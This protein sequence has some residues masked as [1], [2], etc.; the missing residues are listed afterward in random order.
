MGGFNTFE[1]HAKNPYGGD[2]SW[3][4]H[5]DKSI[6]VVEAILP[7]GDRHQEFLIQLDHLAAFFN[8]LVDDDGK[9]I[10]I[11]FRPWHEHTGSWFWWGKENCSEA[12]YI[13]LW[14]FTVNYLSV[15]K[16][17]NNL[18]YAYSP[19]KIDTV[20]EYLY[21]YPGDEY[22]DILGLD[23]YGDLRQDATNMARFVNMLEII[24]SL[25]NEKYKPAALTETGS[26]TLFGNATMP[27]KNWFTKKLIKGIMRNE[28]TRQFSYIMVWRNANSGHFHTPYPG[29]PAIP[30][31]IDFYNH[32]YTLF[33]SDM[34][35]TQD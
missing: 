5:P 32:P 28:L 14:Q 16:E 18:L 30:D 6:N 1:W 17:V 12:E 2:Y 9:K 13:Q 4:N 29:H 22:I 27:E 7:S 34:G 25:A 33:M 31:F 11:I 23:N 21:G 20:E 24:V 19:D 3:E 15:E 10:P 8:T 35:K 26:F